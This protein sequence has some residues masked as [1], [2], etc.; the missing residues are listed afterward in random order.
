MI[1][2]LSAP[3]KKEEIKTRWFMVC[4]KKAIAKPP[5]LHKSVQ[6]ELGDLFLNQF[7]SKEHSTQVLQVWLLGTKGGK[8]RKEIGWKQVRDFFCGLVTLNLTFGVKISQS[9]KV[10]HPKLKH[11]FLSFQPSDTTIP[12][13]ILSNTDR[14]TRN[15]PQIVL[16]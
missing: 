5:V 14:R 11:R 6:L 10:P 13:W 3:I 12:T 8:Q 1:P 7:H 16:G 4:N 9:E 15:L 2:R